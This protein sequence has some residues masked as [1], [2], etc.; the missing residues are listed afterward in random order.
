[1]PLGLSIFKIRLCTP[2]Q[3]LWLHNSLLLYLFLLLDLST[4]IPNLVFLG[5]SFLF[6]KTLYQPFLFYDYIPDLSSHI[7][8]HSL[9]QSTPKLKN[10][11]LCTSMLDGFCTFFLLS[12]VNCILMISVDISTCQGWCSQKTGTVLFLLVF[13]L[14]ST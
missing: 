6:Y 12:R 9:P 3:S 1:M 13:S 11:L 7:Q 8:S 10:F 5:N 4:T 2:R 14:L